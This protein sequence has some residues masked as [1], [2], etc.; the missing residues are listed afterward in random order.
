MVPVACGRAVEP[1][2]FHLA[3]RSRAA[4]YLEGYG[5]SQTG[6]SRS[7]QTVMAV[8][9]D[10]ALSHF[11]KP[12][13]LK[14]DVECAECEVLAGAGELLASARPVVICEVSGA[15]SA[16]VAGFFHSRGY[17]VADADRA[18]TGEDLDAAP[19]NTLAIPV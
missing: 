2:T 12:N 8:S 18:D 13:L 1:R 16:A 3:N 9:L 7:R 15:N 4:N 11:P 14:I 10:W 17:R 19:W 5:S 6:G